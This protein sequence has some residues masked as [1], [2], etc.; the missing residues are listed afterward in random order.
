MKNLTLTILFGFLMLSAWPLSARTGEKIPYS[1]IDASVPDKVTAPQEKHITLKQISNQNVLYLRGTVGSATV[2]L[3]GHTDEL[4]THA[5]LHLHLTFSPAL[6]PAESHLKIS[7]NDEIV[8]IIPVTKEN[9]GHSI[10]QDVEINS[11][12]FTDSNRIKFEFIGHYST[13]CEDPLHTSLWAEISGSSQLDLVVQPLTLKNDLAL[14][15]L[16]FF[17]M[18][19]FTSKVTVPFI[20]SSAPDKS[21]LNAAGII[22]S[23]LGK[24]AAWR[25]SRFPTHLDSLPPGQAIVFATNIDRPGFL[26]KYPKIEGPAL[27]IITNPVDGHSKLLLVLGRDGND[28][29]IAAQTLVLGNAA[30][31]GTRA[32]ISSAK[33]ETLRQAYDAPN[34]V[35]LDKPMKFGELVASPQELQ[36]T[37]H[38]PDAIRLK[39]R[40]PADLF[41][42]RS[43]GVPVDLKYRYTPP[44]RASESRLRMSIN[45][46]LVKSFNLLS[47]GDIEKNRVRLPLLDDTLFGEA[48]EVLL[49]SFKLGSNNELQFIFATPYQK[50]GLCKDSTIENVRAMIDADSTLDFTGFSHYAEMPNLNFFATSGF[51]FTKFADLSQTVVVMPDHPS[52]YDIETML[53]LL[54]RMGES[55]GYP[56]TQFKVAN[57]NDSNLFK[58]ADLLVIG[59][60][61]KQ[62]QLA[63]WGDQLPV[64]VHGAALRVTQPKRSIN[65]LYNWLNFE[66]QPDTAA[67]AQEQLSGNGSLAAMLGFESPVSNKRSVVAVI[68]TRPE[69]LPLALDALDDSA[70]TNNIQGSAVLIHPNKV[71]GFLVGPTYFVGEL[72]FWTSIWYPLANHP[73]LLAILAVLAV[74]VFAFALWRTLKLLAAKRIKGEH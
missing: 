23:W 53:S 30:L 74:L 41:T 2:P 21:T 29:K 33:S 27:E 62:G 14:L 25:G 19:D 65:F 42:W 47:T 73:V 1:V 32:L 10:T 44:I 58:D 70:L 17:N 5:V 26:S 63:K 64:D 56:A 28:Q 36:A 71:E 31:S 59:S 39:L 51:P 12:L 55:T 49:P 15:P 37:G 50:E 6:R 18:Q 3:A 72:P 4:I 60:S 24:L 61:L 34:W 38:Y 54:G 8:S 66:T 45:D 35:R 9:E 16:P 13:E 7:V 11:R 67:L 68:A 52:I 69:Q 46:E 20:F 57:P 48:Q 22:S 40:V 43:R